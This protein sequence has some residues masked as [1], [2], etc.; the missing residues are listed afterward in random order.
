[1]TGRADRTHLYPVI[2]RSENGIALIL[3][4]WILV[5]LSIVALNYL[6]SSR[7]NMASTRNL[8]DETTSYYMALSGYNEAVNYLLADKDQ[9]MDFT[10]ADGNFWTSGDAVPVTGK[11]AV[12][13][14]EVDIEI[15]DEDSKVNINA[16]T[17]EALKSLFSYAG[18]PDDQVQIIVDSLL[19][20]KDSDSD[21]R[22]NGAEDDYYEGLSDPYE[23]KNMNFDLPE[24]LALVRGVK[25]EYLY[26]SKDIKAVLPLITT[27]GSGNINI[28]TVSTEMMQAMGLDEGTIDAIMKQRSGESKGFRA[29]PPEFA[30]LGFRATVTNNLRI[31][32]TARANNGGTASKIVAVINRQYGVHGYKLQNLYWSESAE[33]IRS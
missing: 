17:P 6:S 12:G 2:C 7:W 8:K 27:F 20:W 30:A 24:E 22:L 31:E 32:V 28:N 13:G 3:V 4:L 16:A 15:I 29:V 10:D 18:I 26:G 14:G 23:T 33:N 25:P 9:T 11:K 21:V 5:L 19:D 1:V